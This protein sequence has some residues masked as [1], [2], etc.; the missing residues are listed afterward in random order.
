MANTH[1]HHQESQLTN[2]APLDAANQSL[3]DALR[4]SFNI[5]KFIMFVLVIAFCFSG[6]KCIE[7]NQEA[8]ILRF[9]KILPE[10]KPPGLSCAFP[11][12][13]DDTLVFPTKKN[14]SYRCMSH[15]PRIAK[16]KQHLPL[17]ESRSWGGLNPTKD[18]SLITADKGLVHIQ[19]DLQYRV[20]DLRKYV[21]NV[22]DANINNTDKIE[23][24]LATL[25]ENSAI[26]LVSQYTAESVTRGKTTDIAAA[27]KHMVNEQL[28][29]L[30]TGVRLVSLDIPKSSVPGQTIAAFD[31][32]TKAENQKEKDIRGAEQRESEILNAAAGENYKELVQM[33][34]ELELA[35]AE[36]NKE[37]IAAINLKIDN[38]LE[39]KAAGAAGRAIREAMGFYT[40]VVQGVK[41]DVDEFEASLDEYLQSPVLFIHRMWEKTRERVLASNEVTKHFISPMADEIRIKIGTDPQQR[42]IDERIKLQMEAE[43]FEF[44]TKDKRHYKIAQ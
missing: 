37:K 17:S 33:I 41:G 4:A 14:I 34:D 25:T 10:I 42:L 43:D 40:E 1:H 35:E 36:E 8:V 28:T 38:H 32:V 21:L 22:A 5:L 15:W 12:P 11:Y 23:N 31:A 27:V 6:F 29:E 19:W 20:E 44:R 13:I 39:T 2:E 3:A 24:L 16:D 7:E 26:T 30:E 9:G 18:G